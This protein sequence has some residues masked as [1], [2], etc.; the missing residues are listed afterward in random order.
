[1]ADI[2]NLLFARH[3]RSD[4]SAHILVFRGGK[5]VMS[6]RGL[7]FWFAPMSA[8][9]A[10]VPVDDREIALS[11]HARTADFQD[12]SV[13]GIVT[14]RVLDPAKVAERVDFSID[15]LRGR[16]TKE[17]L[18]SIA[19]Q[20]SQLAQQH[21]ATYVGQTDLR[22][23]LREGAQNIR[24][25]VLSALSADT[26]FA[27]MGLSFT[28]VRV[29][30]ITP[31]NDLERALEAPVRERIQQEA[32]EATFARRALAV[33]KER[34]IQENELQNRI[35]LARREEQLIAQEGANA[36]RKAT[37]ATLAARIETEGRADQRRISA[38]GDADGERMSGQAR[39]EVERAKMDIYRDAPPIVLAALAARDLAQ[40]L[41]RIDHVH[42][43]SDALGP[44]L[45]EL[46]AAGTRALEGGSHG[47]D[48]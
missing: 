35:E 29:A 42:I 47:D 6:G 11:V 5:T 7:A 14:W 3:L 31:T 25:R 23:V 45:A 27:E 28:S 10:E 9:I 43:G 16:H 12:V 24:E 30:A 34:A 36:R 15:T 26:D 39:N 21:A 22:V 48:R 32:D 44:L 17:P 19:L 4:A 2:R 37:E 20:V 46:A 13:Q 33:E 41:E 38:G 8:S 40:K 18:E 1:M